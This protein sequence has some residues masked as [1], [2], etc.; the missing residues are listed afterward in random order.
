MDHKSIA[1]HLAAVLLG[2]A[3]VLVSVRGDVVTTTAPDR[4]DYLRMPES[5]A[6]LDRAIGFYRKGDAAGCLSALQAAV[7]A[8]PELSPPRV[9]LAKMYLLDNRPAPG[10]AELERTAGE[11]PPHPDV[12]LLFGHLALEEGRLSDAG[13]QFEKAAALVAGM[14][15]P[16]QPSW[17][18]RA[19]DGL[20]SV[21][22]RRQDWTSAASALEKWLAID[23]RATRA[24][25][26]LGTARFHLG[27]LDK[28]RADL[29]AASQ[30]DSTLDP[31]DVVLARLHE[32]AGSADQAEAS[33]ESAHKSAPRDWRV[34]AAHAAWLLDHNRADDAR[35]QADEAARL[36]ARAAMPRLLQA[37]IAWQTGRHADAERLLKALRDESPGDL[38]VMNYLALTLGEQDDPAKRRQALELAE[39]QARLRPGSGEALTTLGRVQDRIGDREGAEK[40]LR[41]AI[42]TGGGTPETA[43]YL[44]RAIAPSAPR[45]EVV[46]WLRISLEAPGRFTFRDQA[47]AWKQQLDQ[48]R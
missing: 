27:Q 1:L 12:H 10:R 40:T 42:E 11:G 29:L 37:L 26:R 20:A 22:E 43:Y 32:A 15:A 18:A 47:T 24:R 36:D 31:A 46:R 33:L 39:I 35:K 30:A 2:S 5:S 13:L 38:T 4:R 8:R 9:L 44:A 17:K 16:S 34:P 21:A 6:E 41:A 45:D 3:A 23:P 19:I 28:A 25:A 7:K 48:A 14:P